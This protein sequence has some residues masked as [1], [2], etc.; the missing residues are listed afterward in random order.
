MRNRTIDLQRFAANTNVMGTEGTINATTGTGV[1]YAAG[2]GLSEEMKTYYS[3]YLICY[4]QLLCVCIYIRTNLRFYS[5]LLL[6]VNMCVYFTSVIVKA[7]ELNRQNW[8]TQHNVQFLYNL[9]TLY[10]YIWVYIIILYTCFLF[11]TLTAVSTTSSNRLL[12]EIP[13]HALIKRVCF[14]GSY[15]HG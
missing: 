8:R 4:I 12:C 5:D 6:K 3:D 7:F 13:S 1:A 2:T 15:R 10:T 9:Y 14:F 11:T